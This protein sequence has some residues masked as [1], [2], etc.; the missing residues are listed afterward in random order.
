M[1]LGYLSKMAFRSEADLT[2][3][4]GSAPSPIPTL[5]RIWTG[6]V[7]VSFA[8]TPVGAWAAGLLLAL[9]TAGS[10]ADNSMLAAASTLIKRAYLVL[11]VYFPAYR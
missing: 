10:H 8:G 2:T 7:A 6:P 9:A 5:Q 3:W 4:A 11:M 1:I